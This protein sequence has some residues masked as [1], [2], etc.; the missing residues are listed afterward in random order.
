L[1]GSPSGRRNIE[2]RFESRQDQVEERVGYDLWGRRVER[3]LGIWGCGGGESETG[4]P[5]RGFEFGVISI[6]THR[7]AR[8]RGNLLVSL[9]LHHPSSILWGHSWSINIPIYP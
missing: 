7:E 2:T 6:K 5:P 4:K 9:F 3:E 1:G 8:N